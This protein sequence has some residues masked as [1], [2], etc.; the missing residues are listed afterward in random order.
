MLPVALPLHATNHLTKRHHKCGL[1]VKAQEELATELAGSD[2]QGKAFV[3]KTFNAISPIGL[4]RYPKGKYAV[5]GEESK[6][7]APTM[8]IMLR[9]HQLK[10][11]EVPSTVRAIVR[12]GAGVNNIPVAKMTELGIPVFNTPGANANAVKELVVC[13]LLLASRGILEGYQHVNQ[14]INK[15]ANVSG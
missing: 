10:E 12:C 2:Y 1:R 3:I 13:S 11:E 8:A 6:L 9:S 7:P 4:Q 14:V 5:S 15:E